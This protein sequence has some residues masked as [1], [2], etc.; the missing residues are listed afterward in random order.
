MKKIGDNYD[1]IVIGA[2]PA[3]S[4]AAR[5]LAQAGLQVLVIEQ[6]QKIGDHVQ[7]A[8]FVPLMITKYAD[9]RAG[10]VAQ[11]VT[12]IKTFI[13]GEVASVLRAPGYVLHRA[14]WDK[15]LADAAAAAGA[16]LM[17]GG[18]AVTVNGL[19]VTLLCGNKQQEVT[20]RFIL[21]CDG[22]RSLISKQLGNQ[23]GETC[24]AL[25]QELTLAKPLKYAK[26]YFDPAWYGGYAWVFPK[27]RAANVGLAVHTSYTG[28]LKDLLAEFCCTLVKDQIVLD[29]AGP[30]TTGGLIPSGGLVPC[31][32][33]DHMLVAGD[34]AG[35]THPITGGG[36]MNA[37]VSGQLAANAVI[38]QANSPAG[39][40]LADGYT[41]AIQAEFGRQFAIARNRLANRN[42]GWTDN[43]AEF[44]TLIRR[45]WIAFPEYY[46][47]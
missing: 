13:N 18:R 29:I 9:L 8:E 26:I 28:Q 21:G 19:V 38:M 25:Q 17:T 14:R 1:V 7:C 41:S 27:G 35:C 10:D 23:A 36:I 46:A 5:R 37:V 30:A 43:K 24:I 4:A 39:K 20:G 15:E 11:Q 6:R 31:L 45:N 47:Q 34:A 16:Q 42:Q 12:G 2:G 22:P 3:G 40:H 32:A 33:N 44:T